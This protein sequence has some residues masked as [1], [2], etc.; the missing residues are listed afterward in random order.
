MPITAP[1]VYP[2]VEDV[3]NLTRV[4]LNDTQAGATNTPGEGRTFT[5][6][7]PFTVPC[8]NAAIRHLS[9][10]LPNNSSKTF[11]KDNVI[12]TPVT[13]V[14][15]TDPGLQCFIGFQG[16]FDG[17][18][19]NAAPVLPP[20]CLAVLELWQRT[21]GSNMPFQRTSQPKDGLGSHYPTNYIYEWEYRQDRINFVGA[22]STLDFRIR[23]EAM[24]VTPIS[25]TN[26]AQ[27]SQ[28]TINIEDSTDA[29]AL[30]TAW[31]FAS[32]RSPEQAPVLL[33]KAEAAITELVNRQTRQDQ[34]VPYFRNSFGNEGGDAPG[35]NAW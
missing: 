21:S 8:L 7:A 4:H 30:L 12:L 3:L 2:V 1:G 6:S 16:Y 34:G 25:A 29:L 27:F 24:I 23:Y 19:M 10:R 32:P 33:Q 20:D 31:I 11:I 18:N 13:G 17:V 14:T 22:T 5:D 15:N 35:G 26:V 28:I 9:R